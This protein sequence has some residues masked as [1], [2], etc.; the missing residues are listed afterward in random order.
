MKLEVIQ[1]RTFYEVINTGCG[2]LLSYKARQELDKMTSENCPQFQSQWSVLIHSHSFHG[3]F[4]VQWPGY[5]ESVVLIVRLP[6]H[7]GGL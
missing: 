5:K 1:G 2:L 6:L 3:D 7:A 4:M